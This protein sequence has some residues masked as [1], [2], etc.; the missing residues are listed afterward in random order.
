MWKCRIF[1]TVYFYV[2]QMHVAHW[3]HLFDIIHC[4]VMLLRLLNLIFSEIDCWQV[5]WVLFMR[6]IKHSSLLNEWH[7][8]FDSRIF[9]VENVNEQFPLQILPLNVSLKREPAVFNQQ[10]SREFRFS[11]LMRNNISISH[12]TSFGFQTRNLSCRNFNNI[13][14]KQRSSKSKWLL[15]RNHYI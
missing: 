1:W 6:R 4:I 8:N 9:F 13:A 5:I 15:Y 2:A 10:F 12:W 7:F 11:S 14:N 3:E